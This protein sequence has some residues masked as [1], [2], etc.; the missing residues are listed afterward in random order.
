MTPRDV[1][2]AAGGAAFTFVAFAA[3]APLDRQAVAAEPPKA[4][5]VPFV[6]VAR[7]LED[8]KRD[9][10]AVAGEL[11]YKPVAVHCAVRHDA[12]F[13]LVRLKDAERDTDDLLASWICVDGRCWTADAP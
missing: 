8:G 3:L 2:F 7:R 1:T 10:R 6:E 12:A 4:P 11:G 13:C 9:A 5:P